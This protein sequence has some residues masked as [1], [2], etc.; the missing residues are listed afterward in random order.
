MEKMTI[1]HD[2]YLDRFVKT[3]SLSSNSNSFASYEH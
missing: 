1:C 2:L 3:Q